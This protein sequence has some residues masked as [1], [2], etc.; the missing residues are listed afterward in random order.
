MGNESLPEHSVTIE[1]VEETITGARDSVILRSILF[2]ISDV[3]VAVDV[4]DA[5]KRVSCRERRIDERTR[6]ANRLK[7]LIEDID[8]AGTKIGGVQERATAGIGAESQALV[9]RSG[10]RVIDSDNGMGGVYIRIPAGEEAIFGGEQKPTGAGPPV[11]R[12]EE[13]RPAVE[14]CSGRRTHR[15]S[16]QPRDADNQGRTGRLGLAL[17]IVERR[18]PRAIVRNPERPG[19]SSAQAPGIDEVRVGDTGQSWNIR[20]QIGLEIAATRQA[21]IF[22]SF[23]VKPDPARPL[24]GAGA[25]QQLLSSAKQVSHAAPSGHSSAAARS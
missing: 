6:Q 9:V 25:A 7:R 16:G 18:D 8:G 11:G 19:R 17:T 1:H 12:D 21:P 15:T 20:N 2:G 10:G 3:E 14:N 5:K 23:N 4:L 13:T 22:Q 24:T